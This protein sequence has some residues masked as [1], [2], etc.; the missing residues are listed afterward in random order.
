[1]AGEKFEIYFSQMHKISMK[2]Y[3]IP[4]LHLFSELEKF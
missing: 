4:I 2:I 1:M 3:E